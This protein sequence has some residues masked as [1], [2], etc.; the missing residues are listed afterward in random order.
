MFSLLFVFI[1]DSERGI[2]H[3]HDFVAELSVILIAAVSIHARSRSRNGFLSVQKVVIKM[4]E[5]CVPA[6]LNC[7][8]L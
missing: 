5:C 1:K 7:L 2:S 6:G 8:T 4:V 3:N